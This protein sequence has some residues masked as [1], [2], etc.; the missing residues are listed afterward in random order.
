MLGLL[1]RRPVSAAIPLALV[2]HILAAALGAVFWHAAPRIAIDLPFTDSEL[3]LFAGGSGARLE[4]AAEDLRAVTAERDAA[5]LSR[6]QWSA[7]YRQSETNRNAERSDARQALADL[8]AGHAAELEDA[9]R[10]GANAVRIIYQEPE[11]DENNCPRRDLLGADE[12]R[13]AF[14]ARPPG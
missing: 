4:A 14:G 13:D 11:Y 1:A 9:R 6:D 8:A 3:V 7:S 5:R 10:A 2:T 12:L